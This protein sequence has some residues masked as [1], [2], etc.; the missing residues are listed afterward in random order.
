MEGRE[1]RDGGKGG[2]GRRGGRVEIRREENK[3][4]PFWPGSLL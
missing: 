1:G 4:L 3:C 2:E